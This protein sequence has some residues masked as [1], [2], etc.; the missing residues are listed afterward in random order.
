MAGAQRP[1]RRKP[2]GRVTAHRHPLVRLLSALSQAGR[3]GLGRGVPRRH[4]LD[5]LAQLQ[6]ADPRMGR[7]GH[8]HP[9]ACDVGL[10]AVEVEDVA[11]SLT[12][13]R[14][15]RRLLAQ[16]AAQMVH[17]PRRVRCNRPRPP[18]RRKAAAVE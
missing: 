8:R 15:R 7:P 16:P 5:P 4:L 2:L 11:R 18:S 1:L 12:I 6:H 3:G 10:G 9:Q 17:H 13:T 14:R